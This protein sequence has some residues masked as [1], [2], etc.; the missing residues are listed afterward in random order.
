MIISSA[1]PLEEIL[2]L[3]EDQDN[4]FVI[5]CNTCAAKLH[6]GGEEEVIEMCN[7][8]K[9]SGK[10]VVG[11]TL[12]TAACSIR[13]REHL[14]EKNPAIED[15]GAILVMGCGSGASIVAKVIEKPVYTSNNTDSLGGFSKGDVLYGLCAMCGNCK[16]SD[17]GGICP[18]ARCPKGLLNGPC[19]GSMDGRCE[20]NPQKE[21][22]WE[23]IY[24]RLE[25]IGRLD[26]LDVIWDPK[27]HV[28]KCS[29][30]V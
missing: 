15:A 17:F 24:H 19:G 28:E 12:P 22:A 7:F 29:S 9:G 26:L 6:L 1:K 13:S 8:L 23:L 14:V 2:S 3:L 21:C 25:E 16:I 4:I 30:S 10:K 11:W 5:G 27:D 18:T 20:I